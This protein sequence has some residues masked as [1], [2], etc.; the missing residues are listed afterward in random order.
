MQSTDFSVLTKETYLARI[1]NSVGSHTYRSIFVRKNDTVVDILE[2][3]NLACAHFVSAI[4]Q[5]SGLLPSVH[6]TVAGLEIALQKAGWHK[7]NTLAVGVVIVWEASTAQHGHPH[8]GFYI[9]D[10]TA[11]SNSSKLKKIVKHNIRFGKE[12]RGIHTLYTHKT[13]E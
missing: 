9:G 4:L 5:N 2:E 12:Q 6:A 1:T 8:I 7:T 13:L 11:I 3:G 10:N